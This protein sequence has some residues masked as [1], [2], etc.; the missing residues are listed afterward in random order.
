MSVIYRV[1]RFVASCG[2]VALLTVVASCSE[3]V[4]ASTGPSNPAS[5]TFAAAL[6]VDIGSMTLKT[7]GLYYR[8][9]VVGTGAEAIV[10]RT[11]AVTYTGWLANGTQFDSNVGGGNFTFVLGNGAVI[12]GWDLGMVG[13]KVGGKRKLVIASALAYGQAGRGSIP[14][15]ATLVF[16]V[17]LKS[18]Q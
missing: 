8:D 9:I 1:G 12:S 15:N 18:A 3:N 4:T 7:P 5:E 11:L 2:V 17:E 6:G 13:M 10:G 14:T 16:D